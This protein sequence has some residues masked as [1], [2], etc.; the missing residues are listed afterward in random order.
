MTE[1]TLRERRFLAI[2]LNKAIADAEEGDVEAICWLGSRAA[3]PYF[4]ALEYPQST[5]L[6]RRGWR[7]WAR[8]ALPRC[9]PAQRAHLEAVE[10]YFVDSRIHEPLRGPHS[11][12]NS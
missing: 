1:E 12:A 4:E 5:V 3:T 8:A 9:T 10:S 11:N 6:N 7:E 2:V